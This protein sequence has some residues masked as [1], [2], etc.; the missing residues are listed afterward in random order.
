GR[1]TRVCCQP[2]ALPSRPPTPA[3]I[4]PPAVTPPE[5]QPAI[6]PLAF[7]GSDER[8]TARASVAYVPPMLGDLLVPTGGFR[9]VFFAPRGST[10]TAQ[11]FRLPSANHGFKIADD[12]SPRP[13]NRV[14]TTYNYYNDINTRF[15]GVA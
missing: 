8:A 7:E 12:N 15:D 6:N 5:G 14:F 9:T 1:P 4:Q 11:V 2:A 3:P 13:Q 10:P